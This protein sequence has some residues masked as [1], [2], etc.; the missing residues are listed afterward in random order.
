MIEG[1]KIEQTINQLTRFGRSRDFTEVTNHNCSQNDNHKESA[2]DSGFDLFE[3]LEAKNDF[4][5]LVEQSEFRKKMSASV[6]G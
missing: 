3:P 1:P 4:Y 6:Q 5:A 2:H